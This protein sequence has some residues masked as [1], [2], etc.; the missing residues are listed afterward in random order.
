MWN[1]KASTNRNRQPFGGGGCSPPKALRLLHSTFFNWLSF[2][3]WRLV[4]EYSFLIFELRKN[5]FASNFFFKLYWTF[6]TKNALDVSTILEK[7][8]NKFISSAGT[9]GPVRR[10]SCNNS[11]FFYAMVTMIRSFCHRKGFQRGVPPTEEVFFAF[12]NKLSI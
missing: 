10:C 8:L 3:N 4:Y 12:L 1:P 7:A 6:I 5:I 9:K 2:H 11:L